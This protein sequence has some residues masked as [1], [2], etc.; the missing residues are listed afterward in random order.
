MR[1][2]F[3]GKISFPT[4][5]HPDGRFS[6]C[7]RTLV[8]ESAGTLGAGSCGW[9]LSKRR[10]ASS[11]RNAELA[12]A[13]AVSPMGAPQRAALRSSD[14]KDLLRR[15]HGFPQACVSNSEKK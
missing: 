3:K 6:A 9:E 13:G 14:S 8:E 10:A 11:R 15:P 1:S 5:K 4:W 7:L 2:L 12:P